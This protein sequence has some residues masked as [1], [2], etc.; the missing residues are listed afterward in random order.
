M[1]FSRTKPQK[2][3]GYRQKRVGVSFSKAY[4]LLGRNVHILLPS[5]ITGLAVNMLFAALPWAF[6]SRGDSHIGYW[7]YIFGFATVLVSHLCGTFVMFRA[8][9]DRQ[10]K[11]RRFAF[12]PLCFAR[13][14]AAYI[15]S[16]TLVVRLAFG[17]WFWEGNIFLFVPTAIVGSL[18][19]GVFFLSLKTS[20]RESS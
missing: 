3:P 14:L 9:K 6:D 13:V 12:F 7:I 17:F 1:T 5:F 20:E 4:E 10:P 16:F 8:L 18:S 19:A 11:L 15:L 2:T